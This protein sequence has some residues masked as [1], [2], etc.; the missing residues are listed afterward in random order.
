MATTIAHPSFKLY[1]FGPTETN[2]PVLGA[3]NSTYSAGNVVGSLLSGWFINKFGRKAGMIWSTVTAL[4]GAAITTG[5]VDAGML[6][7]GRIV[8]GIATG[9]LLAIMPPYISEI[10]RPEQRAILVGC[11]G[12]SD[13]VGFMI[14]NWIGYAGGFAPNGDA[15]W[16]IPL[17]TQIPPAIVLIPL[18][19]LLPESP[20]WC[21]ISLV[22]H[23]P[24]LVP[25][26]TRRT[27]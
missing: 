4:V 11:M 20:R 26:L 12:M 6:I 24:F 25:E 21:K 9:A 8:T 22:P 10:S 2:N 13:A 19:I 14:A 27:Q 16:R 18:L 23:S 3:I 5:S 17:A 15:Q 1:M 7:A